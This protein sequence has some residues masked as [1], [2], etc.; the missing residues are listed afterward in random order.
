[1]CTTCSLGLAFQSCGYWAVN[2]ALWNSAP[3]LWP[4]NH[5]GGRDMFHSAIQHRPYLTQQQCHVGARG[6][7]DLQA[8]PCFLHAPRMSTAPLCSHSSDSDMSPQRTWET[9]LPLPHIGKCERSAC[10]SAHAR[11]VIGILCLRSEIHFL[12][13]KS[14][15]PAYRRRSLPETL[16]PSQAVT[17]LQ[18][19]TQLH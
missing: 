10:Q 13:L 4:L 9:L 8:H 18:A 14:D 3:V 11:R 15:C 5:H 7:A 12:C 16:P 2:R 6:S 19:M 17:Q 1:M